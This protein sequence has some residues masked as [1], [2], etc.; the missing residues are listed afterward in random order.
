MNERIQSWVEQIRGG[1]PRAL[2]RA[3]TAIENGA[4]ESLKLLKA[5]FPDTGKARVIG[6]APEGAFVLTFADGEE[7]PGEWWS[8]RDSDGKERR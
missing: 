8:A 7:L 3:I 1:N 4:P 5:L 6:S 2:A